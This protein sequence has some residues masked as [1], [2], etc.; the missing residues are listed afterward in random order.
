MRTMAM[1]ATVVVLLVSSCAL[2][3]GESEPAAGEAQGAVTSFTKTFSF[4]K[5]YIGKS[6][7]VVPARGTVTVA[8]HATWN[9]PAACKLPN[10]DIEL[11]KV[12]LF[13]SEGAKTYTTNGSTTAEAW[14]DLGAGSYHLVFDSI[15]DEI[16]CE[17]TGA[18]T[19]TIKP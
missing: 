16:Q 10:F 4:H 1:S 18:V 9:R 3:F 13:G 17:L 14:T 2:E 6:T 11:V 5:H 12:G 19:V 7:F 15:N 8:A